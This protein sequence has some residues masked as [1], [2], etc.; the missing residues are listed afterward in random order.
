MV[1]VKMAYQKNLFP[2][3]M[4]SGSM[5]LGALMLKEVMFLQGDMA[6]LSINW[7]LGQSSDDIEH[8]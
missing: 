5:N 2:F 6:M 4:T 7:N 8:G 1:Q 3:F